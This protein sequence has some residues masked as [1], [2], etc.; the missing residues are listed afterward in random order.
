M[1]SAGLIS[2]NTALPSCEVASATFSPLAFL[3]TNLAPVKSLPSSPFLITCT[4]PFNP[5]QEYQP[6]LLHLP[7]NLLFLHLRE[8]IL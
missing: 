4:A 2:L 6:L 1:Y 8:Y 3:R 7:L 5:V